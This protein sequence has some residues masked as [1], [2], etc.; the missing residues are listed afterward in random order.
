VAGK[1]LTVMSPAGVITSSLPESGE[2][3]LGR[4]EECEL[5]IDDTKASRR[6]AVIRIANDHVEVEDLGSTNGTL[7][8]D[9]RLQ[10]GE[11]VV[12]AVGDMITIGSTVLTLRSEE[13]R[14]PAVRLWSRDAFLSR[15]DEER[16]RAVLDGSTFAVV[17]VRLEGGSMTDPRKSTSGD[18]ALGDEV[19]RAELLEAALRETLRPTDVVGSYATGA[20][21]VLLPSVSKEEA[22][23]LTDQIRA[24]LGQEG[25]RVE[26]VVACYPRGIAEGAADRT[27]STE[28]LEPLVAKV[29]A[30]DINV[31]ILGETG[32]GKEVLARTIHQRSP[33]SAGPLLCINCAAL[34]STLLESELFGHER[35]AFTGATQSK[36]GL[37]ES[38]QG[39]TVF[40]D[41]VGE[42]TLE[43]QAKLLRVLEQREVLRVGGLKPRSIDVRFL[44]ATNRDLEA[45]VERG[46]FRRDLYFRLNVI[47][48]T[49]PPL[50]ERQGEIVP[51]ASA[52]V[53]EACKRT[54]RP[55][56]PSLSAAVVA[57][58][59]GYGWPGNIR[60]L[61]NVMERAV[62]LCETDEILVEHLPRQ[63]AGVA[64]RPSTPP[65]MAT[66]GSVPQDLAALKEQVATQERE[67]ERQRVVS[68]LEKAAGN[69][70]Q[71]AKLLGISRATLVARL[72]EFDLPRPRKRPTN[73]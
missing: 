39:G 13:P 12:L 22:E 23:R 66:A 29:A 38:A 27:G 48:V 26:V 54:N 35:G 60:E 19:G 31:L 28:R 65:P 21:D 73:E 25:F 6:H 53:L 41:E 3:V 71:A 5:R 8:G 45:E 70:T 47:S 69:Q 32:A 52:F 59:K 62:V 33:R 17:Q 63:V 36:A 1:S 14:A 16:R 9:R 2:I 55:K 34:S 57:A 56:V 61:R 68:A 64:T 49:L 42:M 50:R 58:M 4:G 24:S 67:L 44:S 18:A 72:E 11:P 37:L 15:L 7:V 40:L 43:L 51:L 46:S 20:Y 10:K 30:S